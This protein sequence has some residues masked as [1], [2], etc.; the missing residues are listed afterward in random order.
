M[1]F[2]HNELT[3]RYVLSVSYFTSWIPISEMKQWKS[4]SLIASQL[5]FIGSEIKLKYILNYFQKWKKTLL[6]CLTSS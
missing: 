3:C 4:H 1:I 6:D 5:P 2:W